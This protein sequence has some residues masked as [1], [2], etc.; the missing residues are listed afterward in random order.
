MTM[1]NMMFQN[2]HITPSS[3]GEDASIRYGRAGGIASGV[4]W[5]TACIYDGSFRIRREA[6]DAYGLSISSSGSLGLGTTSPSQKLDVVGNIKVT[7][8]IDGYGQTSG[9]SLWTRDGKV[10]ADTS[11]K[12]VVDYRYEQIRQGWGRSVTSDRFTGMIVWTPVNNDDA[13]AVFFVAENSSSGNGS[14]YRM[15]HQPDYYNSSRDLDYYWSNGKIF[16]KK[17]NMS[18][19]HIDYYRVTIYGV[20]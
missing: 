12:A 8:N 7:G 5:E 3:T 18:S 17:N 4:W 20:N 2:P 10:Y 14:A 9:D 6:N 19:G 16:F 13:A 11:K 1:N 15:T